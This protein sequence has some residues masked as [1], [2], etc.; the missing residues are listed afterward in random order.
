MLNESELPE[1]YDE[2]VLLD[3]L[4]WGESNVRNVE[5]SD[6]LQNSIDRHGFK[7]AVTA[8]LREDGMFE[9]TDGWQRYQSAFNLSIKHIPINVYETKREAMKH[10]RLSSLNREWTQ[11]NTMYHYV[12]DYQTGREIGESHDDAMASTAERGD[13]SKRT[14]ERYITIFKLPLDVHQLIREPD[15][16]IEERLK[17]LERYS[18]GKV[19]LL[20]TED[21]LS[22]RAAYDLAENAELVTESRVKTI[23][24]AVFSL[25]EQYEKEVIRR[26]T[27]ET[28]RKNVEKIVRE[29][30]SESQKNDGRIRLNGSLNTRPEVEDMTRTYLT[31]TRID[32]YTHLKKLL[33]DW[34][35]NENPLMT[36]DVESDNRTLD[37]V[38]NLITDGGNGED[39]DEGN[40]GTT[41][42]DD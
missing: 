25:K 11:Y 15:N 33:E 20:T 5:P 42:T 24:C 36:S 40:V 9:L 28:P 22:S 26:A 3:D 16:R 39:D 6:E 23:A 17:H 8:F 35:A 21:R 34:A 14:L 12:E 2:L 32:I 4:T 1:S 31:N 7:Y 41:T 10:A 30:L 18:K 38:Y 19:N 37:D 13:I 27:E 29:V